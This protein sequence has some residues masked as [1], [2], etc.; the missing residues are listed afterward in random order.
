MTQT[1]QMR[2]EKNGEMME[3]GVVYISTGSAISVSENI[4][5][6]QMKSINSQGESPGIPI[7]ILMKEVEVPPSNCAET[8]PFQWSYGIHTVGVDW[9][10]GGPPASVEALRPITYIQVYFTKVIGDESDPMDVE[11]RDDD[12]NI[13]GFFE[14]VVSGDVLNINPLIEFT[15][16]YLT[17]PIQSLNGITCCQPL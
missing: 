12:D 11:V 7:G 13:A 10:V 1:I 16:V 8:V 3:P 6:V 2:R 17:G 15:E 9:L 5:S 4:V 14:D